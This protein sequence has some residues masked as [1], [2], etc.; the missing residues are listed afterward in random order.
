LFV[1]PLLGL[2]FANAQSGI[3]FG[4]GFGGATAPA[5]KTGIDQ[6][7]LSC[8][9]GSS[10]CASTP[11]LSVFMMGFN[12]DLMLWNHLGIG[13]EVN[14]APAKQDYVQLQQ[15]VV[16]QGIPSIKLQDRVTLWDFNAILQPVKTKR[17]SVKLEGGIGGA[18]IK[19]Y[20]SGTSTTALTGSQNFSQ[21]FGSANHFQVHGGVGLQLYPGEHWFIRPQIDVHYVHNLEQFGRN[22]V[23]RYTIWLGYSFGQ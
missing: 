13:G 3:D 8:S 16:N 11:S 6:N 9:L 4:I 1:L 20:E 5:A 22:A 14:F 18:N 21:L 19:F 17:A 10:G 23:L 12:G 15:Q 2:E 7:L